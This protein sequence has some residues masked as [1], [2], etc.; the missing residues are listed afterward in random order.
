MVKASLIAVVGSI[1]ATMLVIGFGFVVPVSSLRLDPFRRLSE[2]LLGR[3]APRAR[4]VKSAACAWIPSGASAK[5]C[6]ADARLGRALLNP[7]LGAVDDP[8]R[9]VGYAPAAPPKRLCP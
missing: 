5:A 6:W 8:L 9:R 1:T 4:S 3:R 7:S 2:S